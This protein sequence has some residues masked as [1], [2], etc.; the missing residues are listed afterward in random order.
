MI[1]PFCSLSATYSGRVI[2]RPHKVWAKFHV[3]L[4]VR[5][6]L[7]HSG[8]GRGLLCREGRSVL[9]AFSA[10]TCANAWK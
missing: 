4:C 5:V 9:P 10:D 6:H 3:C 1:I 2:T 7:L 8:L